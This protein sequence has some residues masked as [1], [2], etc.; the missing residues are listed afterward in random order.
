MAPN[1]EW[2]EFRAC[3]NL[4]VSTFFPTGTAQ[5]KNALRICSQCKVSKACLDYS[6]SNNIRYGI[7]G[8]KG[9]SQRIRLIQEYQKVHG[10]PVEA[11]WAT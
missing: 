5:Y 11:D 9:E 8:G 10:K 1:E 2:R 3:K 7:W 4:E 6:V